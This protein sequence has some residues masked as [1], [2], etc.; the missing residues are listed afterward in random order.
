MSDFVESS[1]AQREAREEPVW[2]I[3]QLA[4]EFG[5]TLRSIRYYED[6][7]LIAPR[8]EGQTRLYSRRE[9]G[10][11][12]L[13]CRGKRLGFSIGE[14]KQFLD[15]Y[16]T[17]RNQVEQMRYAL[18]HAR[19]RIQALERQL[20]DVKTTLG[21]LRDIEGRIVAHLDTQGLPRDRQSMP[22]PADPGP[23]SSGSERK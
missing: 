12:A 18:G 3:G 15:L 21:E 11:L 7:G 19:Q 20:E 23:D 14:I 2:T 1:G 16:E 13:I 17:D 10:R 6:E 5:L 8:R 4:E 9:R 22:G